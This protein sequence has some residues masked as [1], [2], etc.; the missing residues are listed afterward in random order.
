[1]RFLILFTIVFFIT[2]CSGYQYVSTPQYVPL[3]D[4]KGELKGNIS[5]NSYQLGY[6]LSDNISIFTTGFYRYPASSFNPE[7]MTGKENSGA[8]IRTDNMHDFS[9][10][11]SY[12]IKH[13]V[14]NYELLGGLGFGNINYTST[15]DLSNDYEF[16]MDA[17]KSYVYLQPDFGYKVS[18][19]LEVA[20]FSRFSYN[21]YDNINTSSTIGSNTGIEPDDKYFLNKSN[22]DL[23]FAEPGVAVRVGSKNVKLNTQ[24]SS[25]INL[26]GQNIRYRE[27]NVYLSLFV[28]LNILKEKK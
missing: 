27:I 21:I 18:H 22:V 7:T 9:F 11:A 19:I 4:K 13:K 26:T 20:V 12:F 16:K 17:T 6:S 25:T 15:K 28:N 2:G 3:N 1:M 5:F 23:F 14:F 10:G 8:Y 24:L